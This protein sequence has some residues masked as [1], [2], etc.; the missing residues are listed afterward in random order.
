[1]TINSFGLGYL[2][3]LWS[4]LSVFA[5]IGAYVTAVLEGHVYYF[6]PSIGDTGTKD[7][8]S[9]IFSLLMNISI[10]IGL[11]NYIIRYFQCQYQARQC[12]NEREAIYK[13][14]RVSLMLAV[15]SILGG[16]IV[17][18][19]SLRKEY[20]LLEIHDAGAIVFFLFTTMYFWVQTILSYKVSKF[21]LIS[22][23]MCHVR[24]FLIFTISVFL[25]IN[26]VTSILSYEIFIN[27]NLQHTIAQW[28]PGDFG[29]LIH[30]VSN[31]SEWLSAMFII[32][33]VLTYFEEFQHV[34]LLI[35][36]QERSPM[37]E[38]YDSVGVYSN[39]KFMN[40][41]NNN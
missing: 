7:P 20:Y 26:V 34:V 31:S 1:M 24:C 41:E 10:I 25:C 16:L 23:L 21:G 4:L 8:E 38:F 17:V 9:S 30:I 40:E 35:D 18:N 22:S 36:C 15:G 32:I 11:S 28:V 39:W 14:N 5:F 29:Y 6:L 37:V 12:A 2:P 13:Y 19:I 33:Y 27:Y 3:V